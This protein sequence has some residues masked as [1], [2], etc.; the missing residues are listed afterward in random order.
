LTPATEAILKALT[1][2]L[3]ADPAVGEVVLGG[4]ERTAGGKELAERIASDK[5]LLIVGVEPVN[6]T[7]PT[8]GTREFARW[9]EQMTL[10]VLATRRLSDGADVY[11][12]RFNDGAWLSTVLADFCNT[13]ADPRSPDC[14]DLSNAGI[15]I[16]RATMVQNDYSP[17]EGADLDAG[18]VSVG[19]AAEIHAEVVC[20]DFTLGQPRYYQYGGGTVI[21][22]VTQFRL[23]HGCKAETI[24]TTSPDL[25]RLGRFSLYYCYRGLDSAPRFKVLSVEVKV[26]RAPCDADMTFLVT[27]AGIGG[28]P[29][30]VYTVPV[31]AGA[32]SGLVAPDEVLA[33]ADYQDVTVDGTT[34]TPPGVAPEGIEV[35]FSTE[36]VP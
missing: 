30:K 22:V 32:T 9:Q 10:S 12:T 23:V 3:K 21:Q 28:A 24:P 15:G 29:D 26:L 7:E 36:Y 27:V 8:Q 19:A 2:Y 6:W 11:G 31:L 33:L 1:A 34:D 35:W 20:D 25:F 14:Q 4:F 17:G 18:F 5:L 13:I 16:V